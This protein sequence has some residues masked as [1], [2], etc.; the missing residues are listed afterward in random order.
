MTAVHESTPQQAPHRLRVPH[1]DP[2]TGEVHVRTEV[3]R[4]RTGDDTHRRRRQSGA[5]V[6]QHEP[7]SSRSVD[8]S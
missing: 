7:R 4:A 5:P 8:E 6:K 3:D 2:G 1:A